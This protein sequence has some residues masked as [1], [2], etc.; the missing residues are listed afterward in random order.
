M[1]RSI[2]TEGFRTIFRCTLSPEIVESS[3]SKHL[4]G[5][6]KISY[7][8]NNLPYEV[9]VLQSW[10]LVNKDLKVRSYTELYAPENLHI[11]YNEVRIKAI[12]SKDYILIKKLTSINGADAI[13]EALALFLSYYDNKEF[14]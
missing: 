4:T 6:D 5:K 14:V 8:A 2:T 3:L 9:Y 11:E 12:H 13:I 7:N 10:S 1:S